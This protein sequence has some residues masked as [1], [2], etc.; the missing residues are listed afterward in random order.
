MNQFGWALTLF[1]ALHAGVAATGLRGASIQALGGEGVGEKRYR[2]G[3][4]IAAL[5][6]IVWLIW[7]F[8]QMRAD[9]FDPLNAPLWSPPAW[10]RHITHLLVLLGFVFAA[11]G[12]AAPKPSDDAPARGMLRITRH[13]LLWGV[14][15]WAAGHLLSN[16]ERFAI[17]L[18]GAL[19]VLAL[20]GTRSLDRKA[21]AKD[22]EAWER[23]EA[24]SSNIP[25]A[26]IV[27]G[28]NKL[29]L[30]ELHWRVLVALAAFIT[31]ALLHPILFGVSA[32][33]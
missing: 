12:I 18:F 6:S 9:P 14:M 26:A 1:V 4:G 2:I 8:A 17:M 10:T 3:F 11:G 21:A 13:P 7:A 15:F 30:S 24:V 33:S 27:Q 29:V 28:R 25:F 22:F 23:L 31:I 32:F 20:L 5:A 16:G 19:G